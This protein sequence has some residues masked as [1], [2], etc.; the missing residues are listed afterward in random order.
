MPWLGRWI[1]FDS[2]VG[3]PGLNRYLAFHNAPS[4]HTDPDGN[5]PPLMVNGT[6]TPPVFPNPTPPIISP[7]SGAG[8]VATGPQLPAGGGALATGPQLSAGVAVE[9]LTTAELAAAGG[10][11]GVYALGVALLAAVFLIPVGIVTAGAH[12]VQTK[13]RRYEAEVKIGHEKYLRSLSEADQYVLSAE[14]K[15]ILATEETRQLPGAEQGKEALFPAHEVNKD[16]KAFFPGATIREKD[17]FPGTPVPGEKVILPNPT[18]NAN[19]D[20]ARRK[21]GHPHGHTEIPKR[22]KEITDLSNRIREE[23]PDAIRE[24]V[25]ILHDLLLELGIS[26]EDLPGSYMDALKKIASMAGEGDR[27]AKKFL[28]THLGTKLSEELRILILTEN[29]LA[30]L[31]PNRRPQFQKG[32]ACL[33]GS[34]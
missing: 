18:K 2:G 10:S 8:A 20:V 21:P 16:R 13:S 30:D 34:E 33:R 9:S 23:V 32:N 11:I 27:E 12:D 7:S 15:A 1:S 25:S 3:A 26:Q 17:T 14:D 4:V 19:V 31:D 29:D 24:N 22:K 28:E 5:N 6:P